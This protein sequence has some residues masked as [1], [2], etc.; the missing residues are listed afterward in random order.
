MNPSRRR[1]AVLIALLAAV[2]NLP[3]VHG[4]W[5]QHR[6]ETSGTDVVGNV[7]DDRVVAD[8]EFW[9][10]FTLPADLDP[11]QV[12]RQAKVDEDTYDDAVAEGVVGVRVLEDDLGAYRVDGAAESRAA[13]VATLL[14]DAV[15]LVILALLWRFGGR[16]RSDLRA[17][18]L[19][20]VR[21]CVPETSMERIDGED[22]RIR[23]DVL[24]I[25]EGRV[26][27]DLGNRTVDVLLDGHHNPVGH[28]QAAE[29]HVRLLT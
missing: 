1:S 10:S 9:V 12:A 5:I 11:D 20:D 18:A 27:L 4:A 25:A 19:G 22:Y 16:R 29:V 26:V 3:L 15:L 21:R 7:V 23:G 13:L 17:V 14:A 8:E 28:Q 24:E 6:V 2:I